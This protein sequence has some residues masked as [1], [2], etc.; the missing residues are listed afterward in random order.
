MGRMRPQSMILTLYGDYV[1]HVGG[2]ISIGSLIQLLGC[3]GV[4]PQSVRSAVSRMKQD[5]LLRADHIKGQSSYSLTPKSAKML[6]EGAARIFEFPAPRDSWDGHWHLVTYSIPEISRDARDRLRQELGWMGF[7][8]LTLA[9]W[10]SPYDHRQQIETLANTL[11]VRACIE[12]FTARHD[13]FADPKTIVA[14]C[15]NLQAINARYTTFVQKYKPL[16]EKH[17]LSLEQSNS[18]EPSEHFVRRFSLIHEFRRFPFFDPDLPTELLPSDWR[19]TEAAILF[20]QYHD[21]L[22]E[23]ANAF[24]RAIWENRQ[25]M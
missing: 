4:S 19:G 20:H 3:L 10:I 12:T 2:C 22:A 23:K 7:G 13:G 1:R 14:R 18:P 6:D 11:G 21:R 25:P 9:L 16:Y 15:W 8:M 24:F 17:C 5:D